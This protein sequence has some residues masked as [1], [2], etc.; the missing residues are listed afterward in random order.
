M[1]SPEDVCSVVSVQPFDCPIHE[2][3][4]GMGYQQSVKYQTMLRSSSFMIRKKDYPAGFFLVLKIQDDKDCKITAQE[5]NVE[6]NINN[7]ESL[8]KSFRLKYSILFHL[9]T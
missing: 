9:M 2:D 1:E 4:G 8:E 7:V 3:L 6:W 5:E